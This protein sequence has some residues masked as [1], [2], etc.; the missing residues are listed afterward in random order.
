LTLAFDDLVF[1]IS[2]FFFFEVIQRQSSD[3]SNLPIIPKTSSLSF[4]ASS[5]ITVFRK[6][7]SAEKKDNKG[8]GKGKAKT[9]DFEDEYEVKV[10]ENDRRLPGD[11]NDV[12]HLL[13]G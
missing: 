13:E 11:G 4:Q 5:N 9:V 8:K 1:R 2:I 7:E 12:G 6:L 3:I 10:D